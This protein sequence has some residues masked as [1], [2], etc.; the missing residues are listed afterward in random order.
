MS[1]RSH[2]ASFPIKGP[3]VLLLYNPNSG[4]WHYLPI[5]LY[6]YTPSYNDNIEMYS[7]LNLNMPQF[8]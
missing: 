6:K 8:L 4:F 5:S 2:A 1:S 7:T 3:E